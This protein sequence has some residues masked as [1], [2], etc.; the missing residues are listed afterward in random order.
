[1]IEMLANL[2]LASILSQFTASQAVSAAPLSQQYL[3]Q[4]PEPR[5]VVHPEKRSDAS[6]GVKVSAQS[7]AAA[8][9]E[10]MYLMYEKNPGQVRSIASLTK[11]MT[12]LV[13]L[14][15]NPGMDKEITISKDDL[16]QGNTTYL[17]EGGKYRVGDVF[18]VMLV[19]SANEAAVAL[20]RST[21]LSDE[22]FADAM[23]AKARQLGMA[24]SSFV[25]PTGLSN[26]NRS[27]ARDVIKLAK[28][29][30]ASG[31]ISA[32]AAKKGYIYTELESGLKK[33]APATDKILGSD[34]GY[35]GDIYRILAGKTGYIESAGYCFVSKV[36]DGKGHEVLIAVLGS[37]GPDSR[38]T[39]TKSLA[40]WL[41]T[42]YDW[43]D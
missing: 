33:N 41:F 8:D 34:F 7:V 25:E 43:R 9:A 24:D 11:L 21:G 40:Y 38:F 10:T 23:N 5:K 3:V 27:S 42:S 17:S 4:V 32:T 22:Q 36:S 26:S 2:I 13:F 6:L 35:G 29:A 19:A 31:D 30:F 14:D 20:A 1:M 37:G 16:R 15:H 12:A 28:A 18:N 39:D